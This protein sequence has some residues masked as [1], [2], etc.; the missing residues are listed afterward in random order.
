MLVLE[1]IFVNKKLQEKNEVKTRFFLRKN[2]K[3]K[4][5]SRKGK[6]AKKKKKKKFYY[7]HSIY[8]FVIM[9]ANKKEYLYSLRD[10]L[11]VSHIAK[12]L[13]N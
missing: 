10:L 4:K 13:E 8:N 7:N 11:D 3:K 2:N 12:I 1:N 6:T 9:D 5:R